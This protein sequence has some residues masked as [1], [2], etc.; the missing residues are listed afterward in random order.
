MFNL[1]MNWKLL[2]TMILRLVRLMPLLAAKPQQG[3]TPI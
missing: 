2:M 3:I 1:V